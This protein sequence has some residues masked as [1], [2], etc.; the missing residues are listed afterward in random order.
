MAASH[1]PAR[2]ARV[3]AVLLTTVL[4]AV[5]LPGATAARDADDAAVVFDPQAASTT[6]GAPGGAVDAPVDAPGGAAPL[7]VNRLSALGLRWASMRR[8]GLS[9]VLQQVEGPGVRVDEA[10]LSLAAPPRVALGRVEL[11]LADLLGSGRLPGTAPGS[12]PAPDGAEGTTPGQ[13]ALALPEWLLDV[14]VGSLDVRWKGRALL[15]ALDVQLRDGELLVNGA[16]LSGSARLDG[17]AG[18]LQ[19]VAALDLGWLGA[20]IELDLDRGAGWPVQLRLRQLRVSGARVGSRALRPA[21]VDVQLRRAAGG[22]QGELR[23]AEARVDLD[24]RCGA[25]TMQGCGLSAQLAETPVHGLLEQASDLLELP[26]LPLVSGYLS[27]SAHYAPGGAGQALDLQ[28]RLR[29]FR[30]RGTGI[31]FDRYRYGLFTHEAWSSS[32]ARV[33]LD[34]G[35]GS[36][37]WVGLDAVA[38]VLVAALK[39]AEDGRFDHHPGYDL[40]AMLEV[41]EEVVNHGRPWRGASTLTQQLVKN[42]FLDPRE[43]TL[44]RK[45][46]E[47]LI[48]TELETQLDKWR[49]LELYVNIVEWGP[50]LHGIGP[51]T[52][53]YLDKYPDQLTPYEAAWLVTALPSPRRFH[54]AWQR[55]GTRATGSVERILRRLERS[56]WYDIDAGDGF[57]ATTIDAAAPTDCWAQSQPCV[58]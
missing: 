57:G 51:A 34:S 46:Q 6:P 26:G 55:S 49:I 18:R 21:G 41:V 15:S 11:D 19:G 12:A 35:E 17:A 14:Q 48:A 43:R 5:S 2:P 32:G 23:S 33:I 22:W 38:P 25:A 3:R 20:R 10:T 58:N 56:G 54:A 36:R 52:A 50:D 4:L 1:Q 27:G 9:W 24:V 16:Q 39:T 29:G 42:L 47:L 45:L 37:D 7:E 53:Y 13:T 28:A 40:G 44:Q 30:V 8:D 31:D